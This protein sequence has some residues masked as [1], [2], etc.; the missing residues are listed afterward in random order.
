M[1]AN[2]EFE[3][4]VLEI[5]EKDILKKLGAQKAT[6]IGEYLQRRYVFNTIPFNENRWVRLRSNGENATLAVK[7]IGDDSIS[8]TSEWEVE[9]SSFEETLAILKKIG[10]N[11][12]GYQENRRIA[13]SMDNCQITLDFWPKIPAYLEIEGKNE[14]Q[15]YECAKKL[16]IDKKKIT[17]M[18][19][20]KIYK[21]YGID[22]DEIEDLRF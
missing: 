4:K 3:G 11:P 18:N 16:G 22:L 7:E 12:K 19:T 21:K 17:G 1:S 14:E 6:Y 10:I 5:N 20:T 2:I 8:G 9:V 15:V 13:Y